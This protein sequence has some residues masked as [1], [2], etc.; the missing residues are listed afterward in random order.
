MALFAWFAWLHITVGIAAQVPD[1]ALN[2]SARNAASIALLEMRLEK[3]EQLNGLLL[4]KVKL[5]EVKTCQE[6]VCTM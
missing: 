6:N 4:Q 3:T 5:L 2:I 1:I